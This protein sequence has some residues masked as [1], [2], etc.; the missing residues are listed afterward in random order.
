MSKTPTAF[1]YTYDRKLQI[2]ADIFLGLQWKDDEGKTIVTRLNAGDTLNGKRIAILKLSS[3]VGTA[4]IGAMHWY[5]R[6]EFN[7]HSYSED[8]GCVGG[9]MGKNAPEFPSNMSLQVERRLTKVEYDDSG[10]HLGKIG[11]YTYR[12]NREQDVLP[13]A[14]KTF[15]RKFGPGWVLVPEHW[16]NGERPILCET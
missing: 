15:K 6:I 9:Y 2:P 11:S 4:A 1:E 7:N 5:G 3:Y 10:D 13:H 12:F 16:D 14:L 8:G